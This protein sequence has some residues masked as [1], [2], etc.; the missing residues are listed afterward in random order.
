M[1]ENTSQ[2]PG[3]DLLATVFAP[4]ELVEYQD[5]AVV[6]RTIVEKPAAVAALSRC[7]IKKHRLRRRRV[8]RAKAPS[9]DKFSA[10]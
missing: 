1:E 3:G 2:P 8:F 4:V 9:S 10:Y 7:P 5:G 6:S